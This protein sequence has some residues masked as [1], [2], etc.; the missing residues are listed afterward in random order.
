MDDKVFDRFEIWLVNNH[1]SQFRCLDDLKVL[2]KYY[3]SNNDAEIIRYISENDIEQLFVEIDELM[4]F[5]IL[6][7]PFLGQIDNFNDKNS[8]DKFNS[9]KA[10]FLDVWINCQAIKSKILNLNS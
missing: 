10:S 9:E 8:N 1:I 2:D 3:R 7:F 6:D 4:N 5:I